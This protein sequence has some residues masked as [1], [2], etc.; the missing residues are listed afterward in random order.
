MARVRGEADRQDR[1][2][3]G[4]VA[5]MR[6]AIEAIN[7]LGN[8]RID[9]CSTADDALNKRL[10]RGEYGPDGNL[11]D[12]GFMPYAME[13]AFIKPIVKEILGLMEMLDRSKAN[14]V[15]E[16]ERFRHLIK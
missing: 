9:T 11:W 16:Y 7:G 1:Y 4:M 12:D 14:G 8:D 2:V 5:G 10:G 6:M 15:P 13:G 3:A